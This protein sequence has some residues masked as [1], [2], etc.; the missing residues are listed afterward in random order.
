MELAAGVPWSRA[1][2]VRQGRGGTSGNLGRDNRQPLSR[3]WAR[4]LYVRCFLSGN[5]AGMATF[6]RETG[7]KERHKGRIAT[8]GL[9]FAVPGGSGGAYR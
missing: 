2:G 1:A 3:R 8:T 6:I 4:Q 7:L 5:L 9:S